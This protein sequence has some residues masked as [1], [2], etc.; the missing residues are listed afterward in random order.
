MDWRSVRRE[1][2]CSPSNWFFRILSLRMESIQSWTLERTLLTRTP[3]KNTKLH[4]KIISGPNLSACADWLTGRS[5]CVGWSRKSYG[6]FSW[7]RGRLRCKFIFSVS[8]QIGAKSRAWTVLFA[9]PVV[10]ALLFSFDEF[11]RSAWI[12]WYY[13]QFGLM[14]PQADCVVDVVGEDKRG[15]EKKKTLGR[16][17]WGWMEGMD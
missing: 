10:L 3:T 8:M 13:K 6:Q 16:G 5:C 14:S 12:L 7:S 11:F 15:R 1:S 17:E 2:H 4:K 9:R